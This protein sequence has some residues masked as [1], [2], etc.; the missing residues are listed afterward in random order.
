MQ[1]R[2]LL[3]KLRS[4]SRNCV[5]IYKRGHRILAVALEFVPLEPKSVHRLKQL[6]NKSDKIYF[7]D[8]CKKDKRDAD[9]KQVV[10]VGEK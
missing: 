7:E 5:L 1:Q 4:K 2:S 6:N 10:E 9:I 8:R 3:N